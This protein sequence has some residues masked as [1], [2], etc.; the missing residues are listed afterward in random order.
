MINKY[1][2][3]VAIV[4][5][6][7]DKYQDLWEPLFT[8]F[9]KYWDNCPFKIYLA[10]NYCQYNHQ[11]VSNISIGDDKAYSSNLINIIKQVEEEWIILWY[12]DGFLTKK[13][14]NQLVEYI[15]DIAISRKINY[16]KLTVDYPLY[17]GKKEEDIGLIPK[18]VKYRSAMGMALYHKSTLKNI[19]SPGLSAW[20]LDVS[21]FDD[22]K[23]DFYALNSY[24]RFQRPFTVLNS[25]IKGK[26]YL[27]TPKFLKNEG[28]GNFISNRSIQSFNEYLYIKFYLLRIELYFIFNKYWYK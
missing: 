24:Y 26:W 5:V 3:N 28:L 2:S 21:D 27:G 15:I 7:C 6:S 12:E 10:S 25:V 8:T 11:R 16:L 19:L 9:F 17:Y 13:V 22:S 14:D 4:I 20:E 23:I 18:G 1:S